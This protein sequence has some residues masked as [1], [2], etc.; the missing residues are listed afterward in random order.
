MAPIRRNKEGQKKRRVLQ[1]KH[2][3]I[4]DLGVHFVVPFLF[5]H[6]MTILEFLSD[7]TNFINLIPSPHSFADYFSIFSISIYF[8]KNSASQL[9]YDHNITKICYSILL[10]IN[11]KLKTCEQLRDLQ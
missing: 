10:Q 3:L 5:M 7:H 9:G 4:E 11:N 2:F 1:E 8:H 6:H